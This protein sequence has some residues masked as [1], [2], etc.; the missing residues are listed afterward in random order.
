[1]LV[2]L[3]TANPLIGGVIVVGGWLLDRIFG[4]RR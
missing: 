2:A 3:V 1:L 4:R